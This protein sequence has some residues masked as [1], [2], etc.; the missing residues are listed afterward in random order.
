MGLIDRLF[1]EKNKENDET[2]LQQRTPTDVKIICPYCF[3]AFDHDQ[4]HFRS[5]YMVERSTTDSMDIMSDN[6]ENNGQDNPFVRR[7]RDDKLAV[8]W[9]RFVGDGADLESLYPEKWQYPVI[10]QE[11]KGTMTVND[12]D[13]EGKV[14]YS[15]LHM[16]YFF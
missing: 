7:E 11:N 6:T 10:T 15:C 5:P 1:G 8:F 9:S 14:L 4:V 13:N 12:Y 3:E 2:A 16:T